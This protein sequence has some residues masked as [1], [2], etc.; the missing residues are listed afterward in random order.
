MAPAAAMGTGPGV[1][2]CDS[3]VCGRGLPGR[4][5]SR[6]LPGSKLQ[7]EDFPVFQPARSLLSTGPVSTS[8][9]WGQGG[10]RAS[11][12]GFSQVPAQGSHRGSWA[13]DQEENSQL[14]GS[15]GRGQEPFLR[16]ELS[17]RPSHPWPLGAPDSQGKVTWEPFVTWR[18]ASL[19]LSLTNQLQPWPPTRHLLILIRLCLKMRPLHLQVTWNVWHGQQSPGR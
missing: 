15:R 17:R 12:R 5:L 14:G 18:E 7:I 6:L 11:P 13:A 10:W 2:T 19:S 9:P 3:G 8:T 1:V 16:S 4:H